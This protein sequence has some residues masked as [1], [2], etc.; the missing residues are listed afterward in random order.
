MPVKNSV[1][2]VQTIL[3]FFTLHISTIRI[4]KSR[5]KFEKFGKFTKK[6]VDYKNEQIPQSCKL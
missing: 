6:F 1:K 5:N 4:T 2:N 3:H